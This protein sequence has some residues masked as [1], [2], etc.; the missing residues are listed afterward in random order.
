MDD[1]N[2]DLLTI[3][4]ALDVGVIELDENH[5]IKFYNKKTLSILEIDED[6][7]SKKIGRAHV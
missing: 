6:E 7:N 5:N 1:L 3:I 4:N 2:L